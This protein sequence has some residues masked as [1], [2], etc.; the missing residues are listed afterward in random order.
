MQ[1]R[2]R[3]FRLRELI[4]QKLRQAPI[5]VSDLTLW[6]DQTLDADDEL[7]RALIPEVW[8]VEPKS[9]AGQAHGQERKWFLRVQILRE[10]SV[11]GRQ[12]VGLEP[13]GRLKIDYLGL[14]DDHPVCCDGP[15]AS[16][17]RSRHWRTA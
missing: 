1:D 11:G 16:G 9:E 5:S 8:R 13:M 4:Y 3:R 7:S 17:A 10:L 15:S 14:K 12:R 2:S 6:L